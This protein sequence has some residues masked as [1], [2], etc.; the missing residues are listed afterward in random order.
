MDD[1]D[2]SLHHKMEEKDERNQLDQTAQDVLSKPLDRPEGP[3][4]VTGRATYADE[5][6]PEGTAHGVFVRSTV[7]HGWVTGMNTA[8]LRKMPGVLAVVRDAKMLRNPAQGTAGEA[9]VQNPNEI[10]YVGQPIALVVAET[11]E[12]ARH[13]ALAARPKYEAKD[14]EFEV[15]LEDYETPPK[16]Q[17]SEGDL[18]S[19]MGQAAHSVDSIYTTPAMGH[20]MMEPHAAVAQW[21][22]GKLTIRASCQMLKYNVAELADSL[23]VKAKNVRI[24][25]PYVGG[26]FGGKLGI[27][28]E[29]VAAA[30]AAR[31][32]KRPVSVALHRRN[33]FEATTRRSETRQRLRLCCDDQGHLTGFGHEAWVSSL[34]G[35]SFSEPVTQAS[36]FTYAGDNRVIGHHIARLNITCAGSMR[37]PGEAVGVPIVECAMDELAEKAGIDPV[38]FRLRN[39][40]EKD[41]STGKPYSSNRLADCLTEGA[42][43]FGWEKRGEVAHQREGEWL[44][45]LG[46]ASAV[47]VNMLMNS[48]ATITLDPD[49]HAVVE[50]DMTDIGTGS[51]AILTQLA[52]EMLGL[53]MDRVKTV[54]G[55]SDLPPSSGSG[56]S[57][58]AA[59]AGSSVMLAARALREKIAERLGVEEKD[60]T[61]KD[62]NAISGNK[63]TPLTEI[64]AG[65]RLKA[66]GEIEPGATGDDV[67]QATWGAQ[68][69]E[70]AVSAITG[71]V[72]VRR[73]DATFACGRILNPKTARSQCIGGMVFG[74]GSALTE[75]LSYDLRNG[76]LMT[77][78]LADYHI[79]SNL[80]VPPMNVTFLE[81][82]D[83]YANPMQAKG[84]GELAC[85]GTAGAILNAIH[86]ATGIRVRDFPATPDKVIEAIEAAQGQG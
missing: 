35:E 70:V 30:L 25:S 52:A 73:L 38:D 59:S 64:L 6:H 1:M 63:V 16:K 32:L 2:L 60:V 85:C 10:F 79:P 20:A 39:I 34:H 72:R 23:G 4:K 58:G 75:E 67:R 18:D 41:P 29:A 50:T 71:E 7:A 28:H 44:I 43:A 9:P 48:E 26:G 82:R 68:F 46:V 36:S 83:P 12:Q 53:P 31:K 21:D 84:I 51:Y 74:L 49:G 62:G 45:G 65:E 81:D 86:N 8:A 13:A 57:F 80:D 54:L 61:L 24:L 42:K 55:D 22:G 27:S 11:L 47:R 19:A 17:S 33:V 56:G 69:A 78:D 14:G 76:R 3:L 5:E 66:K 77:R 37:A 40:P 15:P